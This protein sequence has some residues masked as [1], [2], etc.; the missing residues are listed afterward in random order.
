M[1]RKLSFLGSVWLMEKLRKNVKKK[2]N[3]NKRQEK[4]IKIKNKFKHNKLFLHVSSNLFYLF[5]L[6]YEY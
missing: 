1:P 2:K 4:V 3:N 6:L 5:F